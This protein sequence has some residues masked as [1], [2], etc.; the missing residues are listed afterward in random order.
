M[1]IH[2]S[3][4]VDA[5][6]VLIIIFAVII[7]SFLPPD[8]AYTEPFPMNTVSAG[9]SA[10]EDHGRT[11]EEEE[12][13]AEQSYDRQVRYRLQRQMEAMSKY[14]ML[15]CRDV[16]LSRRHCFDNLQLNLLTWDLNWTSKLMN[17]DL[18]LGVFLRFCQHVTCK[19]EGF[20]I[21]LFC[22]KVPKCHSW[23]GGRMSCETLLLSISKCKYK[24]A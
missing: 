17:H 23:V 19:S 7:L 15:Y 12:G 6:I 1:L 11:S 2:S 8:S 10:D 4:S 14:W 20:F 24:C 22:E 13:V 9:L 18:I 16:D 3:C 21:F 5:I